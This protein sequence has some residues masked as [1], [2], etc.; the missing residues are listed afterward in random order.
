MYATLLKS[1]KSGKYKP[2]YFLHG[3]EAFFIDQLVDFF[4]KEVLP[5]DQQA[6][7]LTVL[8]GKET[9][10]KQV[11]DAAR[12]FPMMAERQL[13]ILKEAQEMKSLK[14]LQSYVEQPSPTTLLVIAHKYKKFNFNSK[15]GKAL[16]AKAEVFE[17]KPLYDNQLPDWI[18]SYVQGH[19]LKI[20]L[21]AVALLGEYLGTDLGKVANELDKLALNL[22]PGALI[23]T[24][25]IE[26]QIG[27][28]KDYNVFELQNALGRRDR[29]KVQ[30]IAQYFAANPRKNPTPVVLASLYTFFSRL[31]Q[32][33]FLRNAPEKEILAA[34]GLRSAFFLRDYRMAQRQFNRRQLEEAL[35]LLREYDLKSKGV[36]Y[37]ATGK[38]EG[39]LLQELFWKILHL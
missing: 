36:D 24:K 14:E 20:E 4:E 12:R 35:G 5:E 15:L 10:H 18:E 26:D 19:K 1:L 2:T 38:P 3:G 21:A 8:Y 22:S 28:S 39:A 25:T 31:Y 27:I 7:N 37:V 30:R 23:N 11:V 32:L 29:E 13:V 34:L 9:E 33:A 6:F 17:S 16:K